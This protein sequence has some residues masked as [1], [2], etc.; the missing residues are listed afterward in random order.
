MDVTDAA[1]KIKCPVLIVH[2]ERDAV[3]PIEEGRL[4]ASLIPDGRFVQIDSENHMPSPM[5]RHGRDW[6]KR[7]VDFFGE[8]NAAPATGGLPLG[9][10]T[11]RERDVLEGIAAAFDNAEIASTLKL[12][13]KTVRNHI[14]RVF[15]KI[16]VDHRYQVIVLAREAGLGMK[17]KLTNRAMTRHLS[18]IVLAS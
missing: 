1:R 6:S 17:S 12:S 16:G 8:L 3:V 15:D 13:K 7:Y 9:E 4:L 10:L 11:L 5:N 18:L 2:P 14:T